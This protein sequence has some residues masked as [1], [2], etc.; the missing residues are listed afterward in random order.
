MQNNKFR[1]FIASIGVAAMVTSTLTSAVQPVVIYAENSE[2]LNAEGASQNGGEEPTGEPAAQSMDEGRANESAVQSEDAEEIAAVTEA[3][4]PEAGK[5]EEEISQQDDAASEE[6]RQENSGNETVQEDKAQADSAQEENTQESGSEETEFGEEAA[7]ENSGEEFIEKK[8]DAENENPEDGKDADKENGGDDITK[9]ITSVLTEDIDLGT[10]TTDDAPAYAELKLPKEIDVKVDEE[11]ETVIVTW[12]GEESYHNTEAGTYTFT[13]ELDKDWNKDEDGGALYKLADKVELP[14]ATVTVKEAEHREEAKPSEDTGAAEDKKDEIKKD[15]TAQDETAV[16]DDKSSDKSD[17]RKDTKKDETGKDEIKKNDSKKDDTAKDPSETAREDKK[18]EKSETAKEPEKDKKEV[19]QSASLKAIYKAE[20]GTILCGSVNLSGDTVTVSDKVKDFNGYELRSITLGGEALPEDTTFTKESRTTETKEEIVTETSYTYTVNGEENQIAAGDTAEITYTYAQKEEITPIEVTGAAVDTTGAAIQGD[21]AFNLAIGTNDLAA[22]APY[23]QGYEYQYAEIGTDKITSIDKEVVEAGK[24]AYYVDGALLKE[25]T[26]ITYVYQEDEDYTEQ[27]TGTCGNLTVTVSATKDAKIPEGTKVSV[28]PIESARMSQ[29]MAKV[30]ETLGQDPEN[31]TGVLYDI[32]LDKDGEA[33]QPKESVHVT[34]KF[35]G[36][37][38]WNVPEGKQIADTAVVHMHGGETEVV[39]EDTGDGNAEFETES[40][41]TYGMIAMYDTEQSSSYTVDPTALNLTD[42]VT[43]NGI[44]VSVT[45][46]NVKRD[47]TLNFKLTFEIDD[48]KLGSVVKTKNGSVIHNVWEYDL[49]EFMKN[50]PL[51]QLAKDG[52]G[53]IYDGTEIAGSYRVEGDKLILTVSPDWIKQKET[54]VKG[55]FSFKASL[56]SEEIGTDTE[57]KLEF[58]GTGTTTTIT[59]EDVS[60]TNKKTAGNQNW[61]GNEWTDGSKQSVQKNADGSYTIYYKVETTTNAALDSLILHDTVSEGQTINPGSVTV[62][63]NNNL[64]DL[65][66]TV[67]TVDGNSLT[68]N[69]SKSGEKLP[70]GTYTVT[71]TT[72]VLADKADQELTNSAHWSFDGN[73]T[74]DEG[75][76]KFKIKKDLKVQKVVAESTDEQGRTKYTYTI[77]IGDGSYSLAGHKIEDWMSDNQSL[78]GDFEISSVDAV[79][80][81]LTSDKLKETMDPKLNDDTYTDNNLKLFEYT[82]PEDYTGTGPVTI[83]YSTIVEDSKKGDLFGEKNITNKTTDD[84]DGDHGEDSTSGIHDFGEKQSKGSIAKAGVE[85]DTIDPAKK[86]AEW[87]ITVTVD[88]SVNLPTKITVCGNEWESYLYYGEDSNNGKKVL[89]IDWDNVEVE[90]KTEGT[91]YTVDSENRQ[92]IFNEYKDK[93]RTIVIHVSS[94]IGDAAL[95]DTNGA[96]LRVYNKAYLKIGD[97]DIANAEATLKYVANDYGFSK[98]VEYDKEQDIYKWTVKINSG[99]AHVEPDKHAIFKDT[100]P[101]GMELVPGSLQ[102]AYSGKDTN[103]TEFWESNTATFNNTVLLNGSE[104]DLCNPSLTNWNTAP[105]GISGISYTITYQTKLTDEE[106]AATS[107]VSNTKTYHNAAFVQGQGDTSWK[108]AHAEIDRKYDVLTKKDMSDVDLSNSTQNVIFY[109]IHINKEKL[110]LNAGSVLTLTDP[111]PDGTELVTGKD[112]T[113][114]DAYT[115]QDENGNDITG[116]NVSYDTLNHT[117]TVT[118]P[119]QTYVIFKY[120]VMVENPTGAD[121]REFENTATLKG[122]GTY[123]D[124][125]N[126]KHITV[127]NNSYLVGDASS[128]TI[129]K[130]AENDPNKTLQGATFQLYEVGLNSEGTKP[131]WSAVGNELTTGTDGTVSFPSLNLVKGNSS[132]YTL[133][134][135]KELK[136]PDGYEAGNEYSNGYYFIVYGD[137]DGA[138]AKAEEFATDAKQKLNNKEVHV[139]QGGSIIKVSNKVKQTTEVGGT[140]TWD[141]GNNQDGKRPEKITVNLLANGIKK[142]SKT[143]TEADGWKYKF[144]NL[145]KYENGNEITYT[146]TEDTVDNYT[147]EIDGYNIT[148]SYTPGKTSIGVTKAW[149]DAEN[150]DGK[151]PESVQVQLK[152]DGEKEGDPVTLNAGNKWTYTWTDLDK[153][154]SGKDITYTVEEVKVPDGYTMSVQETTEGNFTVT[155]SHT[156]ETTEVSGTKTW[157]DANNQDGKRPDSITVNLLANGKLKESKTVTK[158]DGWKY[159]FTDLPKYENGSEITYTVTEDTVEDYTTEISDYNITNSYTPGKTSIGVTKSWSDADNQDGKRPESVQVQLK[160]DGAACGDPVTLNAGNEWTYTWTDL[161]KKKS[162]KDI[163]YTV[164]EVKVPDGYTMSVQETTEGNFTVTNSHTP[165][166]T[167][168][169]GTKTW[170]DANNQDGKRPEKITVNLLANGEK[171]KSQDVAPSAEGNWTYKFENLPKYKDGNEIVYTV[172]E[173]AVA[174]YTTTIN[175]YNITNS[176]KPEKTAVS[177]SKAWDDDNNRDNKRPDSIEVRLVAKVDGS[178]IEG[179]SGQT[180]KLNDANGWKYTFTDLPKYHAGKLVEYTVDEV[181]A[182][183]GYAKTVSG[184]ASKGYVITNRYTPE[185]V[186]VAGSKNWNDNGNAAGLRPESITI[187]LYANGKEM[188]HKTVTEKDGWSWNWTGLKRYDTDHKEISYTISEDAVNGYTTEIS[189]FNVTNTVIWQSGSVILTKT[190]EYTGKAL[191]G[192]VFDLYRIGGAK[193]GS[194]TTN[195][196]GVLRVDGLALGDYYFVEMK[197]PDGYVLDSRQIG[198]RITAQTT[199]DAPVMVSMTNKPVEEKIGVSAVKV[200]DDEDNTDGVRSSSVTF[201]LLADG[202]EIG[203]GTA[204]AENGWSVS[205]GE[206]PKTK[207]G[208]DIHYTIV[209]DE[210]GNYY[211]TSY[212]T[213]VGADGSIAFTVKNYRET[214]KHY[215]ERTGSVRGANR[216]RPSNGAGVAGAGRGRGTGD[217]AN[218]MVYGGMSGASLLALIVWMIARK[219]RR[220]H[221]G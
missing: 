88:P 198:F 21:Y 110:E 188:D 203:S 81:A 63:K 220:G 57:T 184:D 177:V 40:F 151:R 130:I 11:K 186:Q 173:D 33:I 17:D 105:C 79:P 101:D 67:N 86:L 168:V 70:A 97:K 135:F 51:M 76:T 191:A 189:G 87:T 129:K 114:E 48:N 84:H 204:S 52:D 199:A 13:S 196:A 95:S 53:T 219:K 111:L 74:S 56:N 43:E 155:N 35:D 68:V 116:G 6:N 38:P 139:H 202:V 28:S 45:E 85:I 192:A 90:G 172:T 176:Y 163:K 175:G 14:Q 133:Y 193:V 66:D 206:L 61:N 60:V 42:I 147:T 215:E 115:L 31:V 197:A 162:G 117:I 82:F 185:T 120:K 9:E 30:S 152:A 169:S 92:I 104:I 15:E 205:F 143:V 108:E 113:G 26:Q 7:E 157:D 34:M 149:S 24:Y 183:A 39:A 99:K 69:L 181:N 73:G 195:A 153:K 166:T 190:D 131:S 122:K 112:A 16:T 145:P 71:Y 47:A 164:E 107:N 27:L 80:S 125:V 59:Y 213:G 64:N 124:T 217:D 10:Y 103:G 102:V 174:D 146:V 165:E 171:V 137:E 8:Q 83:T 2:D 150:Q 72:T 77:T 49:T 138:K 37:I 121:G 134:C 75:K 161:D 106:K 201:R 178:E 65:I 167:E 54:G 109:E 158:A 12:N 58:P 211:E 221:Q 62:Y 210:V 156:P 18:D 144:E 170:D 25:N 50:N 19:S 22:V 32:S 94:I 98:S 46:T 216:N 96:E 214:D 154:K 3:S 36:G 1:K 44:S 140:K 148:N 187:R 41:S 141:D 55:G 23:I 209:E 119:D 142:D 160:A 136:A 78:E 200:W 182:P 132:T 212:E 218:M 159:T 207:N 4:A 5:M 89:P 208:A 127:K 128:I 180:Q 126:K 20:D 91:D 29:I 123:T 100:L 118:V 93:S 194:Y 179:V